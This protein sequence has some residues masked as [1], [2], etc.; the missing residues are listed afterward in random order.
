MRCAACGT[1]TIA[2][3]EYSVAEYMLGTGRVFRYQP[4]GACG[5]STIADP[6]DDLD[7]FYSRSYEP[8]AASDGML[9]MLRR[10]LGLDDRWRALRRVG[11]PHDARVLDVGC[12][13]GAFLR[14]L[15]A[16][17]YRDLTGV[18]PFLPYDPRTDGACRFVRCDLA[19]LRGERFDAVTM[20]HVIEHAR[21][22]RR[23]LQDAAAV[24]APA[25]VLLVRTP[26]MDSWAARTYGPRWV[27]HDAPRHLT[28]LTS[29]GV[30]RAAASAGLRVTGR[31]RDEGRWQA[32]AGAMLADGRNPFGAQSL[33]GRIGRFRYAAAARRRNRDGTGD[34]GCFVLQHAR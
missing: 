31:W 14:T 6:P 18:D 12:G 21:D 10:Y 4:C 34:S 22:T 5:S 25:G 28:L 24:L 33:V 20:H 13:A 29:D 3:R 19:D 30:R 17:G 26:L 7:A 11:V 16:R 1:P 8:F 9:A 2:S 15:E 27:Q 23:F 32:W